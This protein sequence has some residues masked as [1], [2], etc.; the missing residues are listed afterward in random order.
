MVINRRGF[1]ASSA[2]GLAAALTRPS[3]SADVH[4][5]PADH[6]G[7]TTVIKPPHLNEGDVLG[8]A[9]PVPLGLSAQEVDLVSGSLERLGLRVK[10]GSAVQDCIRDRP[11]GD[12][13]RA[14][15]LNA[16]FADPSVKVIVPVRGG[17]GSARLLPL[18]DY[19]L[20]RKNP[21]VVM[22]FSDM[23]ALLLGIQARTGLV[24]FHGPM[25]ISPWVPFTVD[26]MR[27]LL[28]RR[29][30]VKI[31]DP[32]ERDRPEN[33]FRTLCAG[34]ARGR[35]VGG[36][37]TVFSSIVGSPYLTAGDGLI[38][39]LEEVREP[40]SEVDRKLTQLRLAGVLPRVRGLVF[41]QCTGCG[42]APEERFLSLDS[43]L[44]DHFGPMH[45]PAWRGA[46][47]GHIER[48]ITLPIGL[49]VEIDSTLGTIQLLEPA[50]A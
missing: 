9:N 28:F 50:V 34:R 29:E 27:S 3:H 44:M 4:A 18:L 30:A 1:V 37:L 5:G 45:V 36:N 26:H 20:I 33:R 16:L 40:L 38:L 12:A 7:A 8:L 6:A 13:E 15:E 41:G 14:A 42:I 25:G 35:L 11:L 24:T 21:K 17:W 19:E 23:A 32:E 2:A 22:G 48:Q 31:T 39:F 43:V 49:P 10:C 47:I 46:L